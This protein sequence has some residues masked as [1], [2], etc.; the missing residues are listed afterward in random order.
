MQMQK[1]VKTCIQ[2]TTTINYQSWKILH[3]LTKMCTRSS[4]PKISI[5]FC[6]DDGRR[7]ESGSP[8]RGWRRVLARKS[9][10]GVEI[11]ASCRSPGGPEERARPL[12]RTGWRPGSGTA[13]N[14]DCYTL[15]RSSFL[16]E[17]SEESDQRPASAGKTTSTVYRIIPAN[18]QHFS[19]R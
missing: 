1:R 13:R 2:S 17:P 8:T 18:G 6:E 3:F 16:H 7:S 15:G 4:S 9:T 10:S 11:R 14:T 5:V 12:S 19:G